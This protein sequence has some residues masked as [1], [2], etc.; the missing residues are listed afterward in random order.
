VDDKS[1]GLL[2]RKSD[3]E[4]PNNASKTTA[5]CWQQGEF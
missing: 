1:L 3:F 2:L 5:A 4:H